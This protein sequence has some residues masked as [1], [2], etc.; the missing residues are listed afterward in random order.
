MSFQG[1]VVVV[2][3]ISSVVYPMFSTCI[4][5]SWSWVHAISTT[6]TTGLADS[7]ELHVSYQTAQSLQDG[8]TAVPPADTIIEALS[9]CRNSAGFWY[10]CSEK[11]TF[12]CFALI[13][14]YALRRPRIRYVSSATG[15][16]FRLSAPNYRKQRDATGFSLWIRLYCALVYLT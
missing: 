11:S 7:V 14:T 9:G 10:R 15:G 16:D 5:L 12:S 6:T 4:G 8:S 13:D 3:T 1:S 2:V